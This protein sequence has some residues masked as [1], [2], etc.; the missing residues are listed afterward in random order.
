M[1]NALLVFADPRGLD[2]LVGG[3]RARGL[4]PVLSRDEHA[5]GIVR[6]W[7]PDVAILF[8][9]RNEWAPLLRCL[10]RDRVPAVLVASPEDLAM[11]EGSEG[12]V[13]WVPPPPDA[14]GVVTAVQ[15][16]VGAESLTG[17]PDYVEVGAVRLDLAREVAFLDGEPLELPPKEFA[18]LAELALRAGRPVASTELI[19]RVWSGYA[20]ATPAD[21]HRHVHRLRTLLGDHGPHRSLITNRRGFGY[22]LS[23]AG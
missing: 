9:C 10:D 17:R 15:A 7:R 2:G 21:V 14:D 22:V 13:A 1:M 4:I 19:D 6:R 12:A 5:A 8:Q 16:V 11:L 20:S 3:L 23:P 18:I